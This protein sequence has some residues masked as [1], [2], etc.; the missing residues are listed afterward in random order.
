MCP[1]GAYVEMIARKAVAPGYNC[2]PNSRWQS[3]TFVIAVL[4]IISAIAGILLKSEDVS[5]FFSTI[6]RTILYNSDLLFGSDCKRES[7]ISQAAD[8]ISLLVRWNERVV[9]M[10]SYT[11]VI[12]MERMSGNY[13]FSENFVCIQLRMRNFVYA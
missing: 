9:T 11:D 4:S 7:Y 2:S 10:H 6:P 3:T 8:D 1:G 12:E 13:S 5:L